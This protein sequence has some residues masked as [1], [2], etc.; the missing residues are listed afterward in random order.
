MMHSSF[1]LFPLKLNACVICLWI[2]IVLYN[3]TYDCNIHDLPVFV[4]VQYWQQCDSDTDTVTVSVTD[5]GGGG[6]G[7]IIMFHYY[8]ANIY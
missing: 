8:K 3:L 2:N 4:N 5:V 7:V 6:G 1:W